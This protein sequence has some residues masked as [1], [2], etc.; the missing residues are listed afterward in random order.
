MKETID[1][2]LAQMENRAKRAYPSGRLGANDD[3]ALSYAVAA[4]HKKKVVIIDFGKPVEWVG[5]PES[6]CRNLIQTLISKVDEIATE[7]Q[8]AL[9]ASAPTGMKC[10]DCT[11][12]HEACP[13]CYSAWWKKRHPNVLSV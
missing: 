4:D 5:L 12:D 13:A 6:D 8:S 2:F 3:G 1:R 11:I 10:S 7:P 9:H